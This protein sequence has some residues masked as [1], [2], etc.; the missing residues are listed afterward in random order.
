MYIGYKGVQMTYVDPNTVISPKS[1]WNLSKV[2]INTRQEGWSAA[3]GTWEG[4]PCLVIRWNGSD[5]SIG[6][7]NPQSRGHPTWFVIPKELEGVIR[8]EIGLLKKTSGI[9]SCDISRPD[10]YDFGAWRI[11]ASLGPHVCEKLGN[12]NLTFSIPELPKRK[13]AADKEYGQFLEMEFVGI[14][15]SGKWL[16]H[17]YSNG[18]AEDKNPVT[19]EVFRDAFIQSVTQAVRL[20]K[21]LDE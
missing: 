13:C 11:E 6:L 8:R 7:G 10:G 5:A 19:I 21:V 15:K 20:C 18:V 16:G 9:V 2:L 3:E 17:L 12:S 1:V 4:N 14:F